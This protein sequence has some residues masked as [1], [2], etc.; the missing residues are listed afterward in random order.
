MIGDAV[1]SRFLGEFKT[2]IPLPRNDQLIH[3]DH[4]AYSTCHYLPRPW[5]CLPAMTRGTDRLR[6]RHVVP[7]E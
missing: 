4:C 6:R 7:A 3:D 1:F 5:H 2:S